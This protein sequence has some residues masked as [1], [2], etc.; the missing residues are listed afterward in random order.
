MKYLSNLTTYLTFLQ[1][2]FVLLSRGL[3]CDIKEVGAS[4]SGC[5][6]TTSKNSIFVFLKGTDNT[7]VFSGVNVEHWNR[8]DSE[9]RM[10]ELVFKNDTEAGHKQVEEICNNIYPNCFSW[11]YLL[12]TTKSVNIEWGLESIV[13][14][15]IVAMY[16]GYLV[17]FETLLKVA[18]DI[19]FS[20]TISD[21]LICFESS[22]TVFTESVNMIIVGVTID[23]WIVLS[24]KKPDARALRSVSASFVTTLVA[25]STTFY[26]SHSSISRTF[27]LKAACGVL[28]TFVCRLCRLKWNQ[29]TEYLLV[30]ENSFHVAPIISSVS[31]TTVFTFSLILFVH[32]PHVRF[33]ITDLMS[34]KD[35]NFIFREQFSQNVLSQ[36]LYINATLNSYESS[37]NVIRTMGL[38]KDMSYGNIVGDHF[39]TRWMWDHQV[40]V[41][42]SFIYA[43]D[44]LKKIL[45]PNSCVDCLLCEPAGL[46][47][48][49]KECFLIISA[50]IIVCAFALSLYMNRLAICFVMI[51]SF[52]FGILLCCVFIENTQENVKFSQ[53]M[54]LTVVLGIGVD[55]YM[56]FIFH[57][58]EYLVVDVETCRSVANCFCTT[59]TSSIV[60]YL[61]D[62]EIVTSIG[63]TLSI[64]L[65]IMFVTSCTSY[66]L[67]VYISLAVDFLFFV[68][69]NAF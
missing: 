23:F 40:D 49:M 64:F 51:S 4:D 10:A 11:S 2:F 21:L 47:V 7:S 32:E 56:H 45:G 37:R 6:T 41:D 35:N 33:S 59:V 30:T 55:Y 29:V 65:A 24:S 57:S 53:I 67:F 60:M 54:L 15:V 9:W 26:M 63:R 17:S 48:D 28:C 31:M 36:N 1:F 62:N 13:G 66:I 12:S 27:F 39:A 20:V 3:V 25:F 8:M 52:Y 61:S 46:F 42:N 5:V 44:T 50:V 22:L 69:N 43:L 58:K 14:T 68:D 19:A 16:F 38:T 34:E 18:V